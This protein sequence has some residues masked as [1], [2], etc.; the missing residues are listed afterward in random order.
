MKKVYLVGFIFA[1]NI[2][3]A[4]ANPGGIQGFVA[5]LSSNWQSKNYAAIKTAI[6]ERL[7][8]QGSNDLPALLAKCNYY[9]T[10]ETNTTIIANLVPKMTQVKN[11]LDWSGDK[12][13]EAIVTAAIGNYSDLTAAQQKGFVIGLT[14]QQ[15]DEI[16]LAYPNDFPLKDILERVAAVQYQPTQAGN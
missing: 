14:Q 3:S 8:Q 4:L 11:T 6:N 1:L 13:I 9:T 15:L 10:I 5:N 12:E 2:V 7:K 16:H